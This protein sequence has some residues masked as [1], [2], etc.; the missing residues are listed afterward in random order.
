MY[1]AWNIHTEPESNQACKP[2][3][4]F[5]RNMDVS[6][7]IKWESKLA[8]SRKQDIPQDEWPFN[9][10][11]LKR[12]AEHYSRLKEYQRHKTSVDFSRTHTKIKQLYKD[13]ILKI[14]R[15]MC[16]WTRC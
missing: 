4:K 1:H 11:H 13:I 8:K 14:M 16:V 15:E 3:Y 9:K 2:N 5:T 12:G 7:N 6:K 10:W